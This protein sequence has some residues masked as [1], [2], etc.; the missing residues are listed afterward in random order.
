LIDDLLSYSRAYRVKESVVEVELTNLL[1]QVL[2]DMEDKINER[3]AQITV[4]QLPVIEAVPSQMRQLFQ[5]LISNA[6]KFNH[7]ETPRVRIAVEPA[8]D[9]E[10]QR[11][12][13]L[14]HHPCYSFSVADNGIGFEPKFSE[15]IFVLFQRLH[16]RSAFEGTGLGL[17][18]CRKIVENHQGVIHA[19]SLPGQGA[20]F[21][22]ILP[23]KQARF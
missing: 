12:G 11:N 14:T 10:K 2:G 20:T 15:Q 6:L 23:E 1:D 21:T 16:G 9:T 19:D 13:L 5:N 4:D 17:A 22:F 18:I 3:G 7:E 8:S